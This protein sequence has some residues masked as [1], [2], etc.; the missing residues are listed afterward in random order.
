MTIQ[1]KLREKDAKI[2]HLFKEGVFW[3]AYESDAYRVSQ[4]KNLKPTKK[5]VKAVQQEVV[6]VGFPHSSLEGVLSYFTVKERGDTLV[7]MESSVPVDMD[8][9]GE[10]KNQ[11]QLQ[12]KAITSSPVLNDANNAA[13]QLLFEK[14]RSFKLYTASPMDCMRFIEE[15]QSEF[16]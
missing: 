2:V 13:G 3:V 1:E 15:L 9:F 14:V 4:V 11:M 16:C 10:W 8:A 12:T 5:Y 6:S 7:V